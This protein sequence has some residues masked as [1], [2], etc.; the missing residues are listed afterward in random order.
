MSRFRSLSFRLRGTSGFVIT[1][2]R[3]VGATS[4]RGNYRPRRPRA[5]PSSLVPYKIL[6]YEDEYED[7]YEKNQIRSHASGLRLFLFS[8]FRIPTSE[9]LTPYTM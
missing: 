5:R 4:R 6:I 9:F 2:P 7:E 8:A 3:H 1:T